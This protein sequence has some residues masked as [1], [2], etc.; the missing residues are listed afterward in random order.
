MLSLTRRSHPEP[1]HNIAADL[2]GALRP[3]RVTHRAAIVEP[4]KVEQLLRDIDAYEGYFPLVCA[5]KLAPLVFT[6]PTELRAAHWSEF[7]PDEKEWRIPAER[8]KQL[9]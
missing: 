1:S 9:R 6:R 4:S 5:L 7:D 8:M 3:R 2:R